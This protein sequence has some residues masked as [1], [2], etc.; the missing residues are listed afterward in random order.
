MEESVLAPSNPYAATKAA[1][2]CMVKAYAVSFHLP[3]IITRSNNVYG[4]AQYPEKIIPKFICRLLEAKSCF[5]HGDGSHSRRY[6]YVSDVVHAL[7]I[8]LHRG[9]I[10][11]VYNIGTSVEVT[12]LDLARLLIS[13]LQGEVHPEKWITFVRDRAYNDRRYAIDSTKILE[14]GWQE[15]VSFEDGIH[16]TIDWYRK[17]GKDWWSDTSCI[18][19]PHGSRRMATE[20]G[21]DD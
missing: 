8:I 3:V 14:L 9:K 13:K 11:E 10:G 2:E 7:D 17:Y 4:P 18:H 6:L 1:A 21:K 5:V 16:L 20:I 19:V 12:N 15:Q